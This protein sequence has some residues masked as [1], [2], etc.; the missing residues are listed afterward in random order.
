MEMAYQLMSQLLL[1]RDGGQGADDEAKQGR[2]PNH[3]LFCRLERMNCAC[4]LL[5]GSIVNESF[6]IILARFVKVFLEIYLFTFLQNTLIDLIKYVAK[7]TVTE[8]CKP[9]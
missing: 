6:C 1:V 5:K 2:V 4:F 3:L 9:F 7:T 8:R